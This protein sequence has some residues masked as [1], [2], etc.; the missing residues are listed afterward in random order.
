MSATCVQVKLWLP[1]FQVVL[2]RDAS[3]KTDLRLRNTGL[4]TV[5][6]CFKEENLLEV[7][8]KYLV[9]LL[10]RLVITIVLKS[11]H[12]YNHWNIILNSKD[13][14]W[15]LYYKIFN[16]K[17]FFQNRRDA[18]KDYNMESGGGDSFWSHALKDELEMVLLHYNSSSLLIWS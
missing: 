14:F 3:L 7:V 9:H 8:K 18:Q 1:T 11:S 16:F 17:R 2:M 15:I 4:I 5:M 13:I 12:E 6:T 10:T